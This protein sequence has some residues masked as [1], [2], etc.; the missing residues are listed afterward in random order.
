[1]WW[2][3]DLASINMNGMGMRGTIPTCL[4]SADSKVIALDLG[5]PLQ[6][7]VA[8]ASLAVSITWVGWRIFLFSE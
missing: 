3:A 5:M 4:Y 1:M 7:D 8:A 6:H 2:Q